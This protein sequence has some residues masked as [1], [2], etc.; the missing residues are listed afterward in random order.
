MSTYRVDMMVMKDGTINLDN[1]PFHAGDSVEI[2]I[3][4]RSHHV[5]END[6][7]PLQGKLNYYNRPTDPVAEDDWDVLQ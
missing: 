2:I 1:V 3:I 7:Q 5:N 4:P 6:I